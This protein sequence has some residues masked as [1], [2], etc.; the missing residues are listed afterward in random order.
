M[1]QVIVQQ[2][3]HRTK[4]GNP[5]LKF[6]KLLLGRSQTL[7]VTLYNDGIIPA[8]VKLEMVTPSSGILMLFLQISQ[9]LLQQTTVTIFTTLTDSLS[10]AEINR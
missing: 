8:T 5:L 6:K 4:N 9:F 2:P 3:T 7:P 1:P 10:L